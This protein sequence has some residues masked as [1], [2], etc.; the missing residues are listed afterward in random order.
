[1]ATK[2]IRKKIKLQ[3]LWKNSFVF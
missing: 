3:H 2:L 1:V